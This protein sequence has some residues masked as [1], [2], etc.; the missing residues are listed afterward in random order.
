MG[1][2]WDWLTRHWAMLMPLVL[3]AV[4]VALLL[5]RGPGRRT[6]GGAVG[7]AALAAA[8]FLLVA[9]TGRHVTDL[10]FYV[11]SGVAIVSGVLMITNRNP[12][13]AALW[14]ALVTL[15]VCGLFLVRSAAFLAAATVVVYAGAIIVT[16]L[17]VIM[18]ARQAGS[19]GYEQR[20]AQPI[21][22]TVTGFI[23]LGG[24]LYTL[25][26][27]RGPDAEGGRGRAVAR[28]EA[29]EPAARRFLTPPEAANANP[30]SR[31]VE[32]SEFGS[33]HGL[34]R[35]LF[36]DYLFA[37]ELAGTLLLVAAIG[38]IAIA[39]RRSQGTL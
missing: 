1:A 39:P 33:M 32:G 34:G 4:A 23:L 14:F 38:A 7:L 5:P 11:F 27:W 28:N 24:L 25:Q 13:H 37:V 35:S 19:A 29:A 26:Q 22:A 6:A 8:G 9:P 2:V 30:L 20:A 18:L 16:F 12:V 17:F 31:P 10:L 3:G 21:A 15:S 36:G